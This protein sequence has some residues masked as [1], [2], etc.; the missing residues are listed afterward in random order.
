MTTVAS[1]GALNT[2]TRV[3]PAQHFV[4]PKFAKMRAQLPAMKNETG[5]LAAIGGVVVKGVLAVVPFAALGWLFFA[6]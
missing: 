4:M 1:M 6:V 3:Q 5:S 2:T